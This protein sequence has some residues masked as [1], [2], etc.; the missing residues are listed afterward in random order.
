MT[1]MDGVCG[2]VQ[3]ELSYDSHVFAEAF[4]RHNEWDA[5]SFLFEPYWDIWAFRH[6]DIHPYD[7]Y[8]PYNNRNREL[9]TSLSAA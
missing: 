9:L 5:I 7:Q 2:G 3:Q 6:K 1:D 4:E 8:G